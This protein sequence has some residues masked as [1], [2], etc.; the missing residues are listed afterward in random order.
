MKTRFNV[1]LWGGG[2]LLASCLASLLIPIATK[3]LLILI[4]LWFV[5]CAIFEIYCRIK[6]SKYIKINRD[7][8]PRRVVVLNDGYD[9]VEGCI[10]KINKLYVLG[11]NKSCQKI[12][13]ENWD[14]AFKWQDGSKNSDISIGTRNLVN[15]FEPTDQGIF[16][17][18]QD[19]NL[20]PLPIYKD[21]KNGDG[22]R[23][24]KYQIEIILFGNG[25]TDGGT[26]SIK[27]K[28]YWEIHYQSKGI[29]YAP[30]FK[31]EK[32]KKMDVPTGVVEEEQFSISGNYNFILSKS[33]N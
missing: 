28:T 3:V 14:Y 15:I 9:I 20:L 11:R 12:A 6:E 7:I 31:M 32:I 23:R 10:V 24:G 8:D 19:I 13:D 5:G 17:L 16:L 22:A 26:D 29:G 30:K 21:M 1:Y 4:I 2:I 18:F 27:K 33:E 25:K